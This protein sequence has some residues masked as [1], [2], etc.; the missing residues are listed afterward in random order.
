QAFV[1]HSPGDAYLKRLRDA[2]ALDRVV[3]GERSDYARVRAVSRWVR[4]RWEHNGSNEP[5]KPDPISILREAAEGKRFRCVEYAVVLSGAL[6]SVGI[7]ARVLAL[8]TEDAETRESGAGH[9]VAEAY[10][11]DL[12]KWVMVDGQFDV[13]PTLKGRPLNA[14]ELQRALARGEKRLGVDSLSGASAEKY[15]AW[16][17][18]YLYFFDTKFDSRFEGAESKQSLMLVPVGAKPPA[19]FQ[20]KWPL[21]MVYTNSLRAFY[22]KPS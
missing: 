17:A 19:V 14:V 2:Y 8:K 12:K 1:R 13:I 3:A 4:S 6:N 15:F 10:L 22:P 16:V 18:P 11:A 7:P 5:Q 9:V 21:R 20:R